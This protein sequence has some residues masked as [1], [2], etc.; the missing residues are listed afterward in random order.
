[1]KKLSILI[2]TIC[3]IIAFGQKISDYKYVS[4]PEKFQTFKNSFDLENFLA[5]ALKGKKYVILQD[6]KLKWPSEAM[7]NSCSI[8][9]ADVINDKTMLRNRVILQF[10]DCNG[11]TILESKGNSTIKEFEEGFQDALK[12]ALV[13]VP[14][15][16][17]VAI[18]A[19]KEAETPVNNNVSS[20]VAVSAESTASKY[21]N[22]KVDLQKVQID[23]SQF[24]LVKPNSSLPFATFKSTTK[25][26][27][28]RVKLETGDSTIGYFENGNI[29]IEIP[30]KNGEYAKEVF[31]GK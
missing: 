6:D 13:V 15:S 3:S 19:Q 7:G 21:S 25:A 10:K 27:V 1:M 20:T 2:L 29:V 28:F 18:V 4:I 24:I 22:G 30:Q 12:Q 11:K 8:I 23:N 9:N 31:A 26:D 16:N 5:N 14:I 17:P